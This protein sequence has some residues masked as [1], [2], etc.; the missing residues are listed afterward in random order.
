VLELWR[1]NPKR[2]EGCRVCDP[3]PNSAPRSALLAV[4]RGVDHILA[5]MAHAARR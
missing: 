1:C 5:D 4:K 2:M 3:P